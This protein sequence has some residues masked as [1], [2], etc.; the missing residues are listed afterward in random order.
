A[1]T[2]NDERCARVAGEA[3]VAA[4]GVERVDAECAP[5]MPS[6][7]FGVFAR[8]VPACFSFIGNG[9][10]EGEGGTPLHSRSYDAN[11]DVLAAGVAFYGAVVRAELAPLVTGPE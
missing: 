8:H 1:P 3:A 9:T 6:E 2:I 11:D 10:A 4:L 5:I 7:D